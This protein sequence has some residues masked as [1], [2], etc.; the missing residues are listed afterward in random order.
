MP[1]GAFVTCCCYRVSL[2]Q[3]TAGALLNI[4]LSRGCPKVGEMGDP[5]QEGPLGPGESSMQVDPGS[6]FCPIEGSTRNWEQAQGKGMISRQGGESL[7]P[8]TVAWSQTLGVTA[9]SLSA[10]GR[11]SWGAPAAAEDTH[12]A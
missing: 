6:S 5:V 1:P 8:H 3:G 4:S 9:C 7:W 2:C 10:G 12:A 11:A